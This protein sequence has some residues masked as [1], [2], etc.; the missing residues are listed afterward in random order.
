LIKNVVHAVT[1][2]I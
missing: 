1:S 2:V